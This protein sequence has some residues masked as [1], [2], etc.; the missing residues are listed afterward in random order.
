MIPF[1]ITISDTE[2]ISANSL[3]SVKP[4]ASKSNLEKRLLKQP[5]SKSNLDPLQRNKRK[6]NDKE[7]ENISSPFKKMRC[8]TI[9]QS[10]P[11]ASSPASPQVRRE[12]GEKI[13]LPRLVGIL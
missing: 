5:T 13:E 1:Y 2:Y 6:W 9:S 3:F 10:S 11:L 7:K 8:E 4:T 12:R